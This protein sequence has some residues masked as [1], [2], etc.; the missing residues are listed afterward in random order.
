[1]Q[2]SSYETSPRPVSLGGMIHIPFQIVFEHLSV[3]SVT[4]K[5]VLTPDLVIDDRLGL[6]QEPYLV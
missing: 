2:P 6:D 3:Q 5:R 4:V 1:M